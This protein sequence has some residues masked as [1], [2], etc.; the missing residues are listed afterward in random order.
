MGGT[1]DPAALKQHMT[2]T[3]F[4]FSPEIAPPIC[5]TPFGAKM[6]SGF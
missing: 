2:V 6:R 4:P 3:F 5:F 1:Y